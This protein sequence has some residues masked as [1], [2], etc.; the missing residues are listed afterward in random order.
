MKYREFSD[1][2]IFQHS[3]KGRRLFMTGHKNCLQSEYLLGL[4]H[5]LIKN[6]FPGRGLA[7]FEKHWVRG[8]LDTA[9]C[10][11]SSVTDY[12][13]ARRHRGSMLLD[14]FLILTRKVWSF[15]QCITFFLTFEILPL[16]KDSLL[17]LFCADTFGAVR[18]F[19]CVYV[20]RQIQC[21]TRDYRTQAL[22]GI[23][24]DGAGFKSG[25]LASAD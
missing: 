14:S 11:N 16:A 17:K 20:W 12:W 13:C 25:I 19:L 24:N 3:G 4:G 8:H 6:N 21:A 15:S 18:L 2:E 7:K 10:G 23:E 1:I 9:R 22:N 5:R